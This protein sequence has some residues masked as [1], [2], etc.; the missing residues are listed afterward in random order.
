LLRRK[1]RK[2]ERT[3]GGTKKEKAIFKNQMM[4]ISTIK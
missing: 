4:R 3:K 1:I 2:G